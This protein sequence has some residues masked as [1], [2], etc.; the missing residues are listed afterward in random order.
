MDFA[1]AGGGDGWRLGG[2]PAPSWWLLEV[3]GETVEVELAAGTE[4]DPT[5]IHAR[6]GDTLWLAKDGYVH[7]VREPAIEDTLLDANDGT[8]KAPMPGNVIDVRVAEG[9]SVKEGQTLIVMESMKMELSLTSP[10]AGTVARLEATAGTRVKEGA[11]VG[12]DRA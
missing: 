8:V 6:D 11:T 4:P 7:R 3:D 12:G 9:D 1:A 10:A 5:W 2:P